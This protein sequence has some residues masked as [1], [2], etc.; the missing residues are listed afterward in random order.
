MN[1]EI[2]FVPALT[3]KDLEVLRTVKVVT[4]YVVMDGGNKDQCKC[5]QLII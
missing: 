4:G 2:K 5:H 3:A 1:D